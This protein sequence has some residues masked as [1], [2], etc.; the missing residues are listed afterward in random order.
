ME[1]I[2]L[3]TISIQM[4]VYNTAWGFRPMRT[5]PAFPRTDSRLPR[6]RFTDHLG[7]T[8]ESVG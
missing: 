4:I 6:M 1:T 7:A 5:T 3:Q 8:R 2:N